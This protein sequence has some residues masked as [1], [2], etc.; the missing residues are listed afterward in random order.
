MCVL[1]FFRC[2]CF[3]ACPASL[4]TQLYKSCVRSRLRSH[5]MCCRVMCWKLDGVGVTQSINGAQ[6]PAGRD[7]S[8]RAIKWRLPASFYEKRK[9]M[10]SNFVD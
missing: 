1:I 6:V 8:Y 10:A 4:V 3:V 2:V 9:H 5:V 7:D